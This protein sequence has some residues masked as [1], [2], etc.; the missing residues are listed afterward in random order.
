MKIS[1][2]NYVDHAYIYTFCIKCIR[3]V[4]YV[5]NINANIRINNDDEQVAKKP[6]TLEEIY[7]QIY[8]AAGFNGTWISDTEIMMI[9]FIKSDITVYDVVTKK[10]KWIFD[11]LTLSVRIFYNL[12][13]NLILERLQSV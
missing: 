11:G 1:N 3:L 4:P 6:F 8:R 12:L 7:L 2:F 13:C 10:T 5:N 9:N